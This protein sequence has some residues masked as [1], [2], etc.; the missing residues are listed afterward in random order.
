MTELPDKTRLP[1]YCDDPTEAQKLSDQN[2]WNV[3]VFV[4]SHIN[5]NPPD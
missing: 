4:Q 3:R 5:G 2:G 1:N